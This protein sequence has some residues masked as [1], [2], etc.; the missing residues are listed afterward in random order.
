MRAIEVDLVLAMVRKA[1]QVGLTV[2]RN[3]TQK[4]CSS[5][6]E[7]GECFKK[8]ASIDCATKI[9]YVVN[10]GFEIRTGYDVY[11]ENRVMGKLNLKYSDDEKPAKGCVARLIVKRRCNIAKLINK[12]CKWTHQNKI[13]KKEHRTKLR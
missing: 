10:E 5:L 2:Q 9:N 6:K 3:D 4:L 11:A 1:Q 12:R 13:T 7:I 8:D